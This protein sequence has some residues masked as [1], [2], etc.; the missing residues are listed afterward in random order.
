[1]GVTIERTEGNIEV[2]RVEGALRKPEFDSVI[3]AEVK[4]WGPEEHVKL[5]VL[6]AGFGGW[7]GSEEWGDVSFFIEYGDRIDRIAIVADRKW[8]TDL[9]L[10]AAAGFWH[11]PV[12]FFTPDQAAK[13]R[14][15]L[16]GS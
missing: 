5:L 6:A 8:E 15:W 10:F 2:L 7:V 4:R 9:M 12:E 3:K 11:A 13:A 1:M 14:A 16:A